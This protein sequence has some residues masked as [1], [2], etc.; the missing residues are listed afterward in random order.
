MQKIKIASIETKEGDNP[1]GHWISYIF[2]GEDKAKFSMFEPNN[3]GLKPSGL[4]VGDTID[5]EI[6]VKGKFN[7]LKSFTLI[8][9]GSPIASPAAGQSKGGDPQRWQDSPEKRASIEA[10]AAWY[11]VVNLL[12]GK[13]IDLNNPLAQRALVWAE[14]KLLPLPSIAS[15]PIIT[16]GKVEARKASAPPAVVTKTVAPARDPATIR[17]IGDLRT[18]LLKDFGIQPKE[19]L[20]ELNLNSWGELSIL[21]SEAYIKVA[22]AHPAG[23][24][25]I[26]EGG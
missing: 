21:P 5:A 18:A 16:G 8:E 7:N 2:T 20:V 15:S 1:K 23:A 26:E 4:A 19:Q 3:A 22:S 6:E 24:K 14:S 11:G 9:H 13:V 12:V 10:Q 25:V 17:T